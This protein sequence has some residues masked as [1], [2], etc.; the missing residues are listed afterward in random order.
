MAFPYETFLLATLVLS[1]SCQVLTISV[2]FYHCWK[3]PQSK[4]F[5][6]LGILRRALLQLHSPYMVRVLSWAA[7]FFFVSAAVIEM[8]WIVSFSDSC[9]DVT[10]FPSDGELEAMDPD[11]GGI[12]VRCAIHITAGATILCTIAN[13]FG[14]KGFGVKELGMTQLTSMILA[15]LLLLILLQGC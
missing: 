6:N 12:G 7:H 4:R 1:I 2:S 13:H 3:Q 14:V 5:F 9:T 15:Y 8:L 10:G 11:I